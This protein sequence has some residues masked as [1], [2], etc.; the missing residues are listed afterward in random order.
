MNLV[1]K[2]LHHEF[3][4]VT[5]PDEI[6]KL[7]QKAEARIVSANHYGIPYERPEYV[8]PKTAYSEL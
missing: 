6:E 7:I 8:N 1:V 2:N 4:Q 5:D 3:V